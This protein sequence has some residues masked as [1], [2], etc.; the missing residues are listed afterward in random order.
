M[1]ARTRNDG[2]GKNG[3]WSD[4]LQGRDFSCVLSVLVLERLG[5]V[6]PLD[7]PYPS[8]STRGEAILKMR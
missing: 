5:P 1:K 7:L 3:Q 2:D 4:G 8:V 6:I